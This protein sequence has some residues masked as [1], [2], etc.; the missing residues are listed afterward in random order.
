MPSTY[1]FL[2]CDRSETIFLLAIDA[3]SMQPEKKSLIS[4]KPIAPRDIR[5]STEKQSSTGWQAE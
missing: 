3:K 2:A 1:I 5:S 4:E